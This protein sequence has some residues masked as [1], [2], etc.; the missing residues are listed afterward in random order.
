[1]AGV[2]CPGGIVSAYAWDLP[3]G[4]FPYAILQAS[5]LEMGIQIPTAPSPEAARIPVLMEFWKGAN[6]EQVETKV[7]TVERAFARD[8]LLTK[9]VASLIALA[10]MR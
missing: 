6:L 1:M 8:Y 9:V 3:D 2:V 10:H 7:I 4:G 5:L